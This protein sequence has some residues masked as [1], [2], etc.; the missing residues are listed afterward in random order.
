LVLNI[1][2]SQTRRALSG[3][4]V[5]DAVHDRG[6]FISLILIG[7]SAVVLVLTVLYKHLAGA[8]KEPGV[9]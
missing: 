8:D 9:R 3:A 4:A 6:G 7:I 5:S 1:R 2:A